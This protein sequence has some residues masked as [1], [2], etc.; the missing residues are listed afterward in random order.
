MYENQIFYCMKK[1]KCY[2]V[3]TRRDPPLWKTLGGASM[4]WIPALRNTCVHGKKKK[5]KRLCKTSCAIHLQFYGCKKSNERN[6][7]E[8][9]FKNILEVDKEC[10]HLI[11]NHNTTIFI[12][13]YGQISLVWCLRRAMCFKRFSSIER[14]IP[15]VKERRATRAHN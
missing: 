12:E 8:F 3:S 11:D 10:S 7:F 9:F 14:S 1:V 4:R 13:N 15:V 6:L 5:F 2:L